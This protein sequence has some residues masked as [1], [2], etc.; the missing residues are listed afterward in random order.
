MDSSQMGTGNAPTHEREISGY[1]AEIDAMQARVRAIGRNL[2]ELDMVKAS[3]AGEEAH[4]ALH[5]FWS[6]IAWVA[7]DMGVNPGGGNPV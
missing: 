1:L 2:R 4:A 5:G 7:V 3:D 6:A